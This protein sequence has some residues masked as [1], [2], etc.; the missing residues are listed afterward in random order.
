MKSI[1]GWLFRLELK[2]L[3]KRLNFSGGEVYLW[4]NYDAL[5]LTRILT[6]V[7]LSM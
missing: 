1:F 7:K 3:I 5:K 4:L 2:K 6:R